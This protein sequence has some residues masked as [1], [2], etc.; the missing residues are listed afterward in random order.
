M[1]VALI[2][3]DKANH[4]DV[5]TQNR[6]AHL[7]YIKSSGKMAQAGP[8]LDE[9]GEMIG[10]LIVLEVDSFPDAQNWAQNDPYAKAGLFESVHLMRWNKVI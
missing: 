4:L 3:H 1:L 9:D 7:A 2:T 6:A 5:R 10:S 8:F